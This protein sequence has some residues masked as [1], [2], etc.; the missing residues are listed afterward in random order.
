VELRVSDE[1]LGRDRNPDNT[2]TEIGL[3]DL[4]RMV[5]S[6]RWTVLGCAVLATAGGAIFAFTAQPMFRAEVVVVQVQQKGLGGTGQLGGLASLAGINLDAGTDQTAMVTLR[7]RDLARDFIEKNNLIPV[8]FPDKWDAAAGKW[9]TGNGPPPD[10][11]D[12][13][14]LLDQHV[15]G[16]IE[17]KR[18]G[19]VRISITWRDPVVAAQWANELVR[20]A[21]QKL[22]SIALDEAAR[23]VA[24]LREQMSATQI[25][26]LQQ[27]IGRALESEMQK[28]MMAK[29]GEEYAFKVVDQA[30]PPRFRDSPKRGL[31]LAMS[32][33]L[34]GFAGV[35]VALL[36]SRLRAGTA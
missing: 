24:F 25:P 28:M 8:L 20:L 33:F 32:A 36:R 31:I 9:K 11:R 34:G 16:I 4:L 19:E 18:T 3:L 30:Y 27:S 1:A 7:S 35:L 13:V 2:T 12:A 10:I 29:G 22:R 6:G 17:T 5:W 23:N 14:A 15:R 26:A 21:N